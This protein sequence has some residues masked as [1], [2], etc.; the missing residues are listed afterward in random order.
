MSHRAGTQTDI[1]EELKLRTSNRK[2]QIIRNN[3]SGGVT[4][5]ICTG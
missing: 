4:S 2:S 1:G 3:F 5:Y